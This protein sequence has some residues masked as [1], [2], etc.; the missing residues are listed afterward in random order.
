MGPWPTVF[1]AERTMK[2]DTPSTPAVG[3]S[4]DLKA[5]YSGNE[6]CNKMAGR[7]LN[8]AGVRDPNDISLA[9]TRILEIVNSGGVDREFLKWCRSYPTSAALNSIDKPWANLI[10]GSVALAIYSDTAVRLKVEQNQL[11]GV[12][13][14][15]GV[16]VDGLKCA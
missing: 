1:G 2:E 4:F 11:V 6:L 7:L 5:Q 15:I 8:W 16:R 14:E 13:G 3:F 10:F 9:T 12:F